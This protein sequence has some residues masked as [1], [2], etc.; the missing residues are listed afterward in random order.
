MDWQF[1]EVIEVS[2]ISIV[3]HWTPS[4]NLFCGIENI[5]ADTYKKKLFQIPGAM[6]DLEQIP[7]GCAFHPRCDFANAQCKIQQ[8]PLFEDRSACWLLKDGSEI[9]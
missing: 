7:Q 3:S 1:D 4:P 5:D 8:P 2:T 6:P 9:S